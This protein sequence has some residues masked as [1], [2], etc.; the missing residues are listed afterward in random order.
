MFISSI[1]FLLLTSLLS[2]LTSSRPLKV[3]RDLLA[4][5]TNLYLVTCSP[6]PPG[7]FPGSLPGGLP[8][9]PPRGPPGRGP[10]VG[11]IPNIGPNFT[12]VAYFAS[13][14]SP[15]S[16]QGNSGQELDSSCSPRPWQ[17]CQG[18]PG[19]EPDKVSIISNPA[20]KW[21][22]ATAQARVFG[23]QEFE[24]AIDADAGSKTKSSISGK[25]KLDNEEFVCFKDGETAIRIW[26]PDLKA[27]C[28]TD[29]WC[30]TLDIGDSSGSM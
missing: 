21:E 17:A 24:A 5:S 7:G 20:A 2:T 23:G 29:Y 28:T 9:G 3:S 25:A 12:A 16:T 19:A 27:R 11:G 22:G 15:N 8:R 26:Q 30:A 10:P 14:I 6:G 1:F 4:S 18:P 13:P